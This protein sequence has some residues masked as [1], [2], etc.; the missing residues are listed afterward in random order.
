LAH[1]FL[2]VDGCG[3]VVGANALASVILRRDDGLLLREGHVRCMRGDDDA[4]LRA[5][6]AACAETSLATGVAAGATVSVRRRSLEPPYTI[7]LSPVS[8]DGALF[9][10]LGGAVALWLTDPDRAPRP[11]VARLRKTYGWTPAETAVALALA[12]GLKLSE[13]ARRDGK[14]VQ[15]VRSQLKVLFHKAGVSTQAQLVRVVLSTAV[16]LDEAARD[17]DRSA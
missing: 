5:S 12:G 4:R 3:R 15:T 13:I 17:G 6:I 7:T 10:R 9:T 11:D 14:S 8:G 16:G 2:V 1:G